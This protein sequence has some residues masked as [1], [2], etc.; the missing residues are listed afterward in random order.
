[1]WEG[2]KVGMPKKEG[3]KPLENVS[4]GQPLGMPLEYISVMTVCICRFK[5]LH[6]LKQ[7]TP[8]NTTPAYNLKEPRTLLAL[9]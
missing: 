4:L 2:R 5:I 1:M 9:S 8:D 6:F 7:E 3:R